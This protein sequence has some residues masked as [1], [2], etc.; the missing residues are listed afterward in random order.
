MDTETFA[1]LTLDPHAG[2]GQV[3]TVDETAD[4]LLFICF[5]A[6]LYEHLYCEPTVKPYPLTV[7][8]EPPAAEALVG[9]RLS[10]PWRN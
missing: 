7:T 8:V 3:R 4:A 9:A 10:Q 5:P 2:T 6:K 1:E